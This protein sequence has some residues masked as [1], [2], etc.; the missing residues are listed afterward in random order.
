MES[1]LICFATPMHFT[2]YEMQQE[3]KGIFIKYQSY[4]ELQVQMKSSMLMGRKS[5]HFSLKLFSESKS[6]L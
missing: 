3:L 2:L 6:D 5:I 4:E 1:N